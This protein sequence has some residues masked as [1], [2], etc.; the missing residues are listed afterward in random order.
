VAERAFKV[1]NVRWGSADSSVDSSRSKPWADADAGG[2][3]SRVR[4]SKGRFTLAAALALAAIAFPASAQVPLTASGL[5]TPTVP[6]RLKI[7][8]QNR[9]FSLLAVDHRGMAFGKSN[10]DDRRLY[11]S[12]NEGRT[13]IPIHRFPSRV[14]L[15][16]VLRDNTLIAHVVP[17]T[18]HITSLFRSG[19]HGRTWKKVFQFAPGYGTLTS[20]SITDDGRYVYVA[21]YN[22]L[23]SG[24]NQ[25]T[26][27]WRSANDGR[28]WSVTH[29]TTEHAHAHF[30][31]ADPY[32]GDI[33]VG[34]GD[35]D[36][37][38]TLERSTDQGRTWQVVCRGHACRA[39]DIAFD[40]SGF[41]IWGEDQ[42]KSFIVRFDLNA[43]T[44]TQE[45]ALEGASYSAFR[46]SR[47]I[48]L[49]GV[50]HEPGPGAD[51]N[52]HLYASN[53]G[54]QSFFDVL[55]RPALKLSDYVLVKV[56]FAFPNHDFPIQ[57]TSYGTI[58]A[59]IVSG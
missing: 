58:V 21:S 13:W 27:V 55:S 34:Y 54:G 36:A 33:Y 32:T 15:V 24:I 12:R 18:T 45:T 9:M 40:P 5:L 20:H 11:R 52:V 10:S 44:L 48:W 23:A 47:L 42:R 46:L 31:Q 28:S 14:D 22:R 43:H 35:S 25:T 41:A 53:D 8:V 57:I 7:V 16:S 51:P 37:V 26:W 1:N 30:V 4:T 39:V 59:R 6:P 17:T 49:V 2:W 38:S 3:S 56:Q 19:D 50:A 29:Q